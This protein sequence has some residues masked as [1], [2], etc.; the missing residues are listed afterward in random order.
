[1]RVRYAETDQMGVV[2]HTNYLIWF[3]VGRAD[4]IRSLGL[5]YRELE[6]MGYH[7]PV[8]EANCRYL[9]PA[10]YDDTVRI[11]T[12]LVE[13]SRVRLRFHYRARLNDENVLLAEGMTHH[14]FVDTSG[15]PRRLPNDSP[16]W[17]VLRP[18]FNRQTDG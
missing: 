10:R 6:S 1:V 4:Y 12:T 9:R 14:V 8:V 5:T 7:L 15:Q 18:F 3:E 17:S 16:F 11:E 2:Y 13:A